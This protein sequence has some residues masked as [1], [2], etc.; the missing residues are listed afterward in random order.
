M[1][2]ST[3]L[4]IILLT[5]TILILKKLGP[6]WFENGFICVSY[7]RSTLQPLLLGSVL[8]DIVSDVNTEMSFFSCIGSLQPTSWRKEPQM[9]MGTEQ[10]C[11]VSSSSDKGSSHQRM[12]CSFHLPSYGAWPI[13]AGV[14]KSH[15]LPSAYPL[16]QQ[17][18]PDPPHQMELTQWKLELKVRS[19]GTNCIDG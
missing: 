14:E 3:V 19:R 15:S 10:G 6:E 2:G 1:S 16:W 9:Y 11:C 13:A 12:K 18:A 7:F 4:W 8:L 17:R 5:Q